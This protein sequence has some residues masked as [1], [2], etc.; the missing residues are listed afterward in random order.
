MLNSQE[1][2]ANT[3]MKMFSQG[4]MQNKQIAGLREQLEQPSDT[5]LNSQSAF[6]TNPPGTAQPGSR[7]H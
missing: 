3:M 2:P 6:N 4:L 7:A 5:N 1:R